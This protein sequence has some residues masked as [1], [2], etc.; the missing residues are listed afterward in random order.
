MFKKSLLL[1]VLFGAL[2]LFIGLGVASADDGAQQFVVTVKNTAAFRFIDSGVFNTP[3]GAAEP[4]PA[5]PGDAYEWTFY[6]NPGDNLT[7]ATMFVQSNDWFFG[8]GLAG[9]PLYDADGNPRTGDVTESV[10]LWDAGSEI[11]QP[12][13]EGPDQAPRQAGPDTGASDPVKRVRMVHSNE[14]PAVSEMVQVELAY[15]G[16]G[17]FHVTINNISGSSAVPS[18]LAPGVG[19][20]HSEPSPLFRYLRAPL[21]N[22]LEE[23]AEDG[24]VAKLGAWLAAQTGINTPLAPVAWTVHQEANALFTVG[25]AASAG[26]EMLAEDGSPVAL[27]DS[28]TEA[29]KGAA[30]IPVGG[31]EPAPIFAPD[32]SYQF[33][34]TAVPG[35]HLSLATMFVQSNDW[36]FSVSNLPLFDAH[37]NALYGDIT[38]YATLYDAGTEVNEEPGFGSNQAPRQAVPN[39]G[40]DE[41]GLIHAVEDATF[42]NPFNQLQI[43][44][45]PM[46]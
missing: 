34:I 46:N 23:L 33:E 10:Y 36:F 32:G 6:G 28:L 38:G 31:T 7:F 37:G 4:G 1:S 29:N 19:V 42:N 11:N 30:A 27:V 18:P 39:T 26:L 24:N 16:D 14:V 45:T 17:Q 20:V 9:I 25:T 41:N 40:A 15:N 8:P 5:F 43:T 3:V 35:D 21:Q 12:V 2:A 44:I 13:G 22:G